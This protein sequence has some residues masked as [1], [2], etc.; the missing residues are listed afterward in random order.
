MVPMYC[1][2]ELTVQQ[3]ELLMSK[4]DLLKED[5]QIKLIHFVKKYYMELNKND[6]VSYSEEERLEIFTRL[7]TL[8][9]SQ[10]LD[11]D[12]LFKILYE[13]LDCGIKTNTMDK[14]LFLEFIGTCD[15]TRYYYKNSA[16]NRDKVNEELRAKGFRRFAQDN[17]FGGSMFRSF[18]SMTEG[19]I[20][21]TYLE[22]FCDQK[23]GSLAQFAN[24]FTEKRIA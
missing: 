23:Q 14:N 17:F 22:Y 10:K 9:K 3:L 19:R 16:E 7:Y 1:I 8:A 4:S 15:Q 18:L 13:I 2:Q 20:I 12:F 24:I 6:D 5:P 21:D 11:R